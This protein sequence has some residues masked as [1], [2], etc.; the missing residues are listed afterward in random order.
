M[1]LNDIM[2]NPINKILINMDVVNIKPITTEDGNIIKLIIEYV[3]S[4]NCNHLSEKLQK[5][6]NNFE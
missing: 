3:P 5:R 6:I 1:K 4:N 2:N